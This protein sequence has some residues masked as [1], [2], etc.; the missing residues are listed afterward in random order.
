VAVRTV[1]ESMQNVP[2]ATRL[3]DSLHSIRVVNAENILTV[4]RL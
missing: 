1:K 3:Q 2:N 4:I